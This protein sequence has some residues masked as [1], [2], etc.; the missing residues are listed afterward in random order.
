MGLSYRYKDLQL[1]QLRSF[2]WVATEGTFANAA[3]ELGLT[4]S[5]VW[6]QVRALE[7]LLGATLVR[8]RGRSVELTP[9]GKLLLEIIQP[10]VGALDSLGKLFAARRAEQP[11]QLTV[12]STTYL[13]SY[14][15]HRPI[16]QFT[17]SHPTVR[18][19]LRAGMLGDALRP[20]ERGE[21]D[22]GVLPRDRDEPFSPHL[23]YERLFDLS[24]LLLTSADHPLAR[25]KQVRP[26]DL[27]EHPI[28]LSSKATHA[29]K[30]FE[31]ILRR[32]DVPV[33]RLHA[34][35]ESDNLEMML[36]YVSMGVG[37]AVR[38]LSSAAIQGVEG[39]K[40]RP[41]GPREEDLPIVLITRKGAHLSGPA[42][43]FRTLVRRT[44]GVRRVAR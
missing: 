6:Q 10:Q 43:D 34:V 26:A 37:C 8:R 39:I 33:E 15:L 36:R 17:R 13:F 44:L 31:R 3:K 11:G 42:E 19:N 9:D 28:I 7:R 20:V 23:D 24:L 30:A 40:R 25:Q 29:R 18:L 27:L 1:P 22:L 5:A 35:M 14:H 12:S 32:H 4:A 16:Q 38:Y 21:A 2:C 41:F